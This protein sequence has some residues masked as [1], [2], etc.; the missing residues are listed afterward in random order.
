MTSVKEDIER[1]RVHGSSRT[2]L[3]PEDGGGPWRPAL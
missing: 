1:G 2:E 3:D